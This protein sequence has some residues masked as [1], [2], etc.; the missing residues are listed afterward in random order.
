LYS[1]VIL[2]DDM[3][4][5]S[6]TVMPMSEHI[7]ESSGNSLSFTCKAVEQR[8][9]GPEATALRTADLVLEPENERTGCGHRTPGKRL[10]C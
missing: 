8:D 6:P 2:H 1:I 3:A 9:L 10:G 5:Q 7:S 4:S